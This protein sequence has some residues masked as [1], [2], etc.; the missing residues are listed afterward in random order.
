MLWWMS[1][2]RLLILAFNWW[3]VNELLYSYMLQAAYSADGFVRTYEA[4]DI[5]N[6]AQWRLMVF[7][8]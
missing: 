4:P 8:F 5:M 7:V 3:I 6:L 1:N 2:L